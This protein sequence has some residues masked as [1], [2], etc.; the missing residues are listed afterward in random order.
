MR[1]VFL[2]VFCCLAGLSATAHAATVTAE[3]KIPTAREDGT[4]LPVSEL[5]TCRL[6]DVTGSTPL[7]LADMG[8]TGVYEHVTTQTGEHKFAA[9]CV[10]KNGL[11][12]KL[13]AAV[14]VSIGSS[15]PPGG[16]RVQIRIK[17]V[18]PAGLK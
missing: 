18:Q 14:S 16:P 6:Y 4:A 3:F 13:S 10:D 8:L 7:K 17:Y 5:A 15:S 9:D 1:N 11:A 12:S 2:A